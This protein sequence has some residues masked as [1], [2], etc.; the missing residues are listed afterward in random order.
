MKDSLVFLEMVRKKV[1]D[2][3]VFARWRA[4]IFHFSDT[5]FYNSPYA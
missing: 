4:E 3:R 2:K 5:V 1:R